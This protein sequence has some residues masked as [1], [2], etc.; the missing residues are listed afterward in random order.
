MP[1]RPGL[2]SNF[3][4][5][6]SHDSH[7][8]RPQARSLAPLCST[9]SGGPFP[10]PLFLS[11]CFLPARAYLPRVSAQPCSPC[12]AALF[13]PDYQH[14]TPVFSPLKNSRRALRPHRVCEAVV[15]E[16]RSFL[17]ASCVQ[18]TIVFVFLASP[19]VRSRSP[20][21]TRPCRRAL[22]CRSLFSAQQGFVLSC[23]A[24]QVRVLGGLAPSVSCLL[25]HAVNPYGH[26]VSLLSM[27]RGVGSLLYPARRVSGIYTHVIVDAQHFCVALRVL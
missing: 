3:A 17:F 10:A 11:W 7:G 4:A 13:C 12:A 25:V 26:G 16:L 2:C 8:A 21:T 24:L 27:Q 14:P 18:H 1:N 5:P 15:V 20:S 6:S 19:G 23:A 22:P 9:P